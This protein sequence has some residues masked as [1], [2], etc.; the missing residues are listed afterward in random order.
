MSVQMLHYFQ[1]CLSCVL[2]E[3]LKQVI[4]CFA[5]ILKFINNLYREYLAPGARDPVNVDCKV[6]ETVKRRITQNPDRY[7]FEEAEV[8][9]CK[10]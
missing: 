1:F 9:S 5:I 3:N 7:C 4:C 2:I 8:C 6:A 10:F